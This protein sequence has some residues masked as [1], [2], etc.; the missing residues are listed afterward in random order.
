[1]T[2]YMMT[3][4]RSR[5]NKALLKKFIDDQDIH[6]WVIGY[7]TGR[8][9]YKHFQVRIQFGGDFTKLKNWFCDAHIEEGSDDWRY[10]RKSGYFISSDDTVE[11][12]KCRFGVLRSNQRRVL[13]ILSRSGNRSIVVW[14]DKR[15]GVGK[16]YFTRNCYEKGLAYYVPPTVNDTKSLIQYVCA[17]Y[18]GEKYIIIDIPRSARWSESLYTAI[19]SIKDGLV[20]DTRYTA[21]IRDIWGVKILVLCNTFPELG[22]LSRDRWTILNKEGYDCSKIAQK[23]WDRLDTSTD[24]S[25]DSSNKSTNSKRSAGRTKK[26]KNEH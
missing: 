16:S 22:A 9:G 24:K 19:E 26:K 20:Y 4:P 13:D 15:G 2:I 8:S 17:G 11:V 6:K 7:E 23:Y 10:E 12:R 18:Q 1:M 14:Y 25:T 21:R 3:M 5:V